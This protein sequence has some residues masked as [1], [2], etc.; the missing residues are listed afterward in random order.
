M[1]SPKPASE[2]LQWHLD[3]PL[4]HAVC[5][6]VLNHLLP[7][8]EHLVAH[9]TLIIFCL[10]EGKLKDKSQVTGNSLNHGFLNHLQQVIPLF[11]NE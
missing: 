4:T 2:L 11:T 7:G 9:L 6:T 8:K 5:F 3:K 1:L 10:F